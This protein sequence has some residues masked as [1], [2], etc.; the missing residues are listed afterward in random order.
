MLKDSREII[1][2]NPIF[3]GSYVVMSFTVMGDYNGPF[4]RGGL[5]S[6]RTN[7]TF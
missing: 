4:S 6:H 7:S 2:F 5:D 3:L 1:G